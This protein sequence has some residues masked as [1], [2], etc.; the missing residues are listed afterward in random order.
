MKQ[1]M[2]QAMKQA[3]KYQHPKPPSSAWVAGFHAHFMPVTQIAEIL[4]A[5]HPRPLPDHC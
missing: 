3:M 5:E 2:W 4:E 1:A